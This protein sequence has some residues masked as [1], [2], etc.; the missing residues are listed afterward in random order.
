MN[1]CRVCAVDI[2]RGAVL[3]RPHSDESRREREAVESYWGDM[4][5]LT[6][7][8]DGGT[9]A[10][11]AEWRSISRSRVSARLKQAHARTDLA[12]RLILEGRWSPL[13]GRGLSLPE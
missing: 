12:S 1:T 4:E 5:L 8:R 11:Y 3:C 9:Q 13:E 2:S 10:E 6:Y 7:L